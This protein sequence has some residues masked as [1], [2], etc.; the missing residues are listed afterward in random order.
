[1]FYNN[2]NKQIP[3]LKI[4]FKLIKLFYFKVMIYNEL[5]LVLIYLENHK[6]F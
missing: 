2:F 4:T 1:M 3:I 5:N 6:D